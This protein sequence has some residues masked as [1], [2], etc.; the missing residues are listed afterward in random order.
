MYPL[1]C[2]AFMLVKNGRL[3]VEKRKLSKKVDPGC[4]S[5]PGG[6]V[7]DGESLE[8]ALYRE[9]DEELGIVPDAVRYICTLI[10]YS[11]EIQKIHYFAIESWDGDISNREA[12]SLHWIQIGEVNNLDIAV[13]RVAVQEYLRVY[14]VVFRDNQE[15]GLCL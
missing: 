14:Q 11:Q 15:G 4:V 13:D 1:D 8:E 2:I 6:H 5:I 10:H 3:L 7:E 9:L 12:D